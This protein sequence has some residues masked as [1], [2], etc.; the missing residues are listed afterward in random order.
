[1]SQFNIYPYK[2]TASAKKLAQV[3][4]ADFITEYENIFRNHAVINWGCSI[5][6]LWWS[7]GDLNHPLAVAKAIN[8]LDTFELLHVI[9][10][11]TPDFTVNPDI[12]KMWFA[13][14]KVV[15][16]RK[17]LEGHGGD[18]IVIM[19]TPEEFTE[20]KLYTLH[21]RHKHEFRV[22]VVKDKV[23]DVTEKRKKRGVD[24][25]I[26]VRNKQ[27]GWV[28]CRD[29]L[30]ISEAVTEQALKAVAALGLDFGA[31]DIAYREKEHKAYVLEVNTA[32]G[33]EGTTLLRY[34]DA[35][36]ALL[37]M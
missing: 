18:G 35:F 36:N 13:D 34:K 8:K 21:L 26:F 6:P 4:E 2:K 10:I 11:N 1:M 33:L 28:Y 16:G 7:N 30:D 19:K 12:V 31:V 14:K 37:V 32:P 24:A 22:H 29:G 27:T 17:K 15:V 25:N 9:R 5:M 23:I 3:L 20:C